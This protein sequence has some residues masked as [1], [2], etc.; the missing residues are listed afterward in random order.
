[1]YARTFHCLV[2]VLFCFLLLLLAAGAGG[3][4]PSL[5]PSRCIVDAD[6]RRACIIMYNI[7]C[8]YYKLK[9][10]TQTLFI[11]CLCWNF[12]SQFHKSNCLLNKIKTLIT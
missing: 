7:L 1:M 4:D 11:K 3:G 6:R 2:L 12:F 8:V 5:F 10:F 9:W